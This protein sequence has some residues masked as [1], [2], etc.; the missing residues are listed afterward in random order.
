MGRMGKIHLTDRD[1]R[2]AAC[3]KQMT[4]KSKCWFTW[5]TVEFD[6]YIT[7]NKTRHPVCKSCAGTRSKP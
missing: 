3:G 1:T 4:N 6:A 2:K 7:N 5:D